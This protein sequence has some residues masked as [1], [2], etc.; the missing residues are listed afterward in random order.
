MVFL[1]LD[2]QR[3]EPKKSRGQRPRATSLRDIIRLP[4]VKR[5]TFYAGFAGS[6]E[7]KGTKAEDTE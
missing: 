2:A 3:K 5:E 6:P 4:A 7:G 1:S